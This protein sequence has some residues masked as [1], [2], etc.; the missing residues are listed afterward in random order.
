MFCLSFLEISEDDKIKAKN[1]RKKKFFFSLTNSYGKSSC[2]K[3]QVI[4]SEK[5]QQQ[6]NER[7]L[8]T[9]TTNLR[10]KEKRTGR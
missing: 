8:K 4:V 6:E 5:L 10:N 2:K 7:N 9:K 3:E 1:T